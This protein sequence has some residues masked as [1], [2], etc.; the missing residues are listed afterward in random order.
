MIFPIKGYLHVPEIKSYINPNGHY[1]K[2][3]P[4]YKNVLL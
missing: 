3:L 4:L 1:V 2:Q